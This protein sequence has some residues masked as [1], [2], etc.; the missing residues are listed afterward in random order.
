MD[1][2]ELKITDRYFVGDALESVQAPTL[3]FHEL[4][5]TSMTAWMWQGGKIY[6]GQ[7]DIIAL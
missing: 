6:R 2:A 3:G 5:T 1:G 4:R 7:F